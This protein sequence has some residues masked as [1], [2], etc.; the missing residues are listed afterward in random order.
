[1]KR[2]IGIV[3][4]AV[5]VAAGGTAWY[6]LEAGEPTP[7]YRLAKIER[8]AIVS[9]VSATGT[10]N[11]VTT[12]QVGSQ[13]SGQ[14]KEL[15]ADFNTK[16]KADQPLA[17]LDTDTIEARLLQARADLDSA[18]AAQVMQAAQV[19]KV[20]ADL[21]NAEAAL[22]VAQAQAQR[23]ELL[24]QDAER[25]NGR[26][27][28][29]V[30]QGY[31]TQADADKA[32]TALDTARS[33][34]IQTRAQVRAV[35]AQ[36][37][38]MQASLRI[39]EAQVATAA[40]QA[41]Q[42]EAMLQ[43][44]RLDLDHATIRAPI[45]GVVVQRSVD[46]GQT[47]AASLQSPTLFNIAQDLRVMQVETSIDEG[48]I[49]RIAEG[50]HATFSVTAFP[51]DTFEGRV[52]QIRLG[53][54]IVQNVVTYVVVIS[55]ENPDMKLLPGMT[56]TVRVVTDRRA[57]AL[58][59][60][61]AALRFRPPGAPAQQ[62]P[63]P[64]AGGGQ[65]IGAGLENLAK[66]LT[67]ELKLT[68][69]QQRAVEDIVAETRAK[70]AELA[71]PEIG[72]SARVARGRFLRNEMN[73]RIITLLTPEQRPQ[74]AALRVNRGAGGSGQIWLMDATGALRAVAVRLGIG[75]GTFTE[76]VR[77][78]SVEEGQTV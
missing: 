1:M 65:R 33:D 23:A 37:A 77:T 16:V 47:V 20:R 9:T 78:G 7:S 45:D 64:P 11:A 63:G 2:W 14:I 3:A 36:L 51:A 56:A 15:Y 39:A 29:L 70:F 24:S 42:R 53:P 38:A 27:Q 76:I 18:R 35:S 8:G 41:A 10:V 57:N 4:A 12:V 55:A 58:K 21:L 62:P 59:A 61:N 66:T 31:T 73:E 54:Q 46:L 68:P 50:Q 60:P 25:E 67:E 48:D 22:A 34:V 17:R 13:L 71:Q 26:K 75:D 49:G 28:Q 30:R 72:N 5:L 6:Y 43:Q 40:A 69:D 44:V 52:S 74:F 19:E 32:K